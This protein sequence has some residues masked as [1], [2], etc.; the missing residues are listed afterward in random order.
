MNVSEY[1]NNHNPNPKKYDYENL[2]GSW[3]IQLKILIHVF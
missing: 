2:I 3:E 1:P